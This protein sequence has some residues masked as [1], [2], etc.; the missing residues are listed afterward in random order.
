MSTDR[1]AGAP[2][3]EVARNERVSRFELVVEGGPAFLDY[4]REG[5]RLYLVHTE[6]P[7]ALEGRGYGGTLVRAAME[8][9]RDA[10]LRVVPL[11]AFARSWVRRHPEYAALVQAG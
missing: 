10:R 11:C 6:V 3:P 9:A 1:A 5:D 8:H 7:R 4:M 2:P